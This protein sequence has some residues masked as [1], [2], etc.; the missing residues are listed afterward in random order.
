MAKINATQ[1]AALEAAGYVI[2]KSGNVVLNSKGETLGGYNENGNIFSGSN[3]VRS[4]LKDN[5]EP[6]KPAAAKPAPK[7]TPSRPAEKPAAKP[8]KGGGRGDG[9]AE[10]NRRRADNYTSSGRGNGKTETARRRTDAA[11][12][13]RTLTTAE[14]AALGAAGVGAAAAAAAGSRTRPKPRPAAS[15]RPYN[16]SYGRGGSG[17]KEGFRGR[18]ETGVSRGGRGPTIDLTRGIGGGA[19]E[20]SLD[21]FSRARDPLMLN[22]AK[23]GYVTKGKK[24]CAKCKGKKCT[25][26]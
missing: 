7:R 11:A 4:I 15:A 1:R 18:M 17:M 3:K 25:C 8:N 23:G 19:G 24:S 21:D 10:V 22:F 26:K 9:K 12:S 5:E 6:K 13:N 20:V 2:S 16:P 14:K